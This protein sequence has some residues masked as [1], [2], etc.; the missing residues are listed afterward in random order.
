MRIRFVLLLLMSIF[1]LSPVFGE[2]FTFP[3]QFVPQAYCFQSPQL[4][5]DSAEYNTLILKVYAKQ[6]GTARIF[7]ANHYDPQFNPP[8]SIGFFLKKG[9]H[10]YTFN[11][12]SQ[13]PYWIGWVKGFLI[14]PEFDP[15]L[16]EIKDAKIIAGNFWTNT[17]SGWQEFWGPRGRLVIGSTINT[18]QSTNLFGRPIYSY[19]YWFLG[20][21]GI[22]SSIYLLYLRQFNWQRIG[23][24]V[25]FSLLICWMLLEFSGL[26]SNWLM[27]QNDL[28]YLSKSTRDK[29][30]LA[31]T[32]DFYPFMEFC[33]TNIPPSAKFNTRIPPLYNNIKAVYYLYPRELSTTEADYLVVY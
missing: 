13:N 4:T 19:I 12:A 21:I 23:Q 17:C 30:V 31:N 32:G 25:F 8:K 15:R 22:G 2:G 11:I 26:C 16:V 5:I 33:L 14:Y 7:W 24:I 29:L 10:A 9:T 3:F 28:K 27:F 20:L 6:S 18:I 1:F